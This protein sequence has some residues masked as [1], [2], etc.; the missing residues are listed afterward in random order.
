MKHLTLYVTL[1]FMLA[2]SACKTKQMVDN[3][4]VTTIKTED[5]VCVKMDDEIFVAYLTS[6][7]EPK[8]DTDEHDLLLNDS[9]TANKSLRNVLQGMLKSPSGREVAIMYRKATSSLKN[10]S[11]S[12]D[13]AITNEKTVADK[14]VASDKDYTCQIVVIV[15]VF[16]VFVCLV[17][18]YRKIIRDFLAKLKK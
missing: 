16:V 2:C 13:S 6:S 18:R 10:H 14:K 8:F 7:G 15:L 5:S 3:K 9:C 4:N 12:L 17:V 11:S 1:L